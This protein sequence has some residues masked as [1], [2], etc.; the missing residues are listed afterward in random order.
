MAWGHF[1]STFL[2]IEFIKNEKPEET[3]TKMKLKDA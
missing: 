2:R 3:K 1:G